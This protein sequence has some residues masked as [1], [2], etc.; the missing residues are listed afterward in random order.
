[1]FIESGSAQKSEFWKKKLD[2]GLN[3]FL[4]GKIKASLEMLSYLIQLHHI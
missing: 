2:K 1:M 3:Y 4:V